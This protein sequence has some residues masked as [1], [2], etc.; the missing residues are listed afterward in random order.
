MKL[1]IATGISGCNRKKYLAGW[2]K[3]CEKKGKKVKI[4][5]VGKMMFEHAESIGLKLNHKN[6]LNADLD[7]LKVLRSAVLK[8]I[9]NE[10]SKN[11]YYD[12]AVICIHGCFYWKKVIM[13]AFD[14]FL[15][16]FSADLFI[17]FI[18]NF[19]DI[20]N[21]LNKRAQWQ[22]E[23]LS[24]EDILRWQNV[25][26]MV[27]HLLANF[28]KKSFFTVPTKSPESTLYKLVFHPEIEPVY[29]AMPISHF[30]DPDQRK[31]IDKFIEKVDQYFTVFH[32]LS[33]E[34]VGAIKITGEKPEL[35]VDYHIVYRDER[36]F[37]RQAEKI[38]VFWPNL[39]PPPPI[40]Q[41]KKLK[42]LWP[43]VVASPGIDHE[44]HEG[45]RKTKEII[46]VFLSQEASPFVTYYAT[47]L[48]FSEKEFFSYLAEKYPERQKMRW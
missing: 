11:S 15:N 3:Y 13:E 43:E 10:I 16:E 7:M 20:R 48:F 27:T 46:T 21:E 5:H 2:E 42:K 45:F 1:I 23:N 12:A 35:T 38:I 33:V 14:E 26:V 4:F 22:N 32:A 6:I 40:Q 34:V 44:T 8:N 24:D 36:W 30:Q 31:T 25:E 41:D 37:V 9:L 19:R 39:V 18:D 28:V 17:T 29:V 47:D